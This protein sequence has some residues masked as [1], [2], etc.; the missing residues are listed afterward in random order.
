MTGSSSVILLLAAAAMATAC[1]SD[2]V[3]QPQDVRFPDSNVSYRGQVQPFLAVTC[4][5]GGCH[6]EINPAGGIRLGSYGP[7]FIDRP[8]L[9]VVGKPDESLVIQVLEG[10]MPHPVGNL[11]GRVSE[12]HRRG[13]RRWILEGALN[14]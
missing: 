8:N 3:T 1:G 7:L 13:M 5:T 4:A 12:N 9:V 2:V 11:V 10:I 14:N 6:G